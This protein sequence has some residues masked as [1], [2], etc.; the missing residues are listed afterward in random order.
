MKQTRICVALKTIFLRT[1]NFGV[2]KC[3]FLLLWSEQILKCI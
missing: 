1:L 3:I 2:M